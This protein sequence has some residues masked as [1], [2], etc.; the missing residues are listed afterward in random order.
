MDDAKLSYELLRQMKHGKD[1]LG[2]LDQWTNPPVPFSQMMS[3]KLERV[4]TLPQIHYHCFQIPKKAG[5]F[6]Q[7][8]APLQPLKGLQHSIAVLLGMVFT[9][10][11]HATGFVSGRSIVDNARRHVGKR[12][13][14][15]LDLKDFF[16]SIRQDR[17]LHS[18]MAEPFGLQEE[19][20]RFIASACCYTFRH[21]R[22]VLAQG[23]PTSPILS[24]IV[25]QEMDRRLQSLA[26]QFDLE[27][28][29]YADDI[30]F[31]GNRYVF[32]EKGTFWNRLRGIIQFQ[33]FQINKKKTRLQKKGERQEV[34]GLTVGE[35]VNVDK[36]Y[37]RQ[38]RTILHLWETHGTAYMKWRF[39]RDVHTDKH[40]SADPVLVIGG[41]LN[42]LKMVR[43][44]A[45]PCYLKLQ[46]RFDRLRK[47]PSDWI[48]DSYKPCN[49]N[50][51]YPIKPKYQYFFK[52]MKTQKI[53]SLDTSL[54]FGKYRGCTI[55]ELVVGKAEQNP[56]Q[57]TSKS[58]MRNPGYLCWLM[59]DADWFV[60]DENA[61]AFC[62][63]HGAIGDTE[64][65]LNKWKLKHSDS[66]TLS[67]NDILL[68]G[69]ERMQKMRSTKKHGMAG[70]PTGFKAL[71][72]M[73]GGLHKGLV[74]VV[75]GR[76]GMGKTS[77]VLSIALNQA[78]GQK[79]PVAFFSLESDASYIGTWLFSLLGQVSIHD[80]ARGILDPN[81]HD[82][83]MKKVAKLKDAPLFIDTAKQ[84]AL[85]QLEMKIVNMVESHFVK[86][87]IIDNIQ[88]LGAGIEPDN[89]SL[90][91]SKAMRML[92]RVAQMADVAIVLTSALNR[93]VEARG[94]D[95]KPILSDL[96]DS[97][98]IEQYSDVVLMLYRPEYYGI[99]YDDRG[100]DTR[101]VLEVI[102]SKNRL[103][104]IG[105]ARLLM[106]LKE[107]IVYDRNEELTE[108]HNEWEM[109]SSG[110]SKL[111]GLGF[112]P[113]G[114]RPF[115]EDFPF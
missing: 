73:I 29:R 54:D 58:D 30:T 20:A 14:L 104:A 67:A 15:N 36:Q 91:I 25:C 10:D 60:M 43:G 31:S 107:G 77:F 109:D 39:R 2:Y 95:K 65:Q 7:I 6:R 113:I 24:N 3:K 21:G 41:K 40:S 52:T 37:I 85:S 83:L 16:P 61:M 51:T 63:A 22:C 74:Y 94:G 32:S 111:K 106:D 72:Q 69:M 84:W 68:S 70:V 100:A 110:L 114:P 96:R 12:F 86:V 81:D 89:I 102:T 90:G 8:I 76:P 49:G 92:R 99:D 45:D 75:A 5:G 9:P 101:D 66:H 18:L 78:I 35:R 80:I 88:L 44:E 23:A 59:G 62:L 115:E 53:Y 105:E 46:S 11:E 79:S 38:L 28:S 97:G 42:Y 71:D 98:D 87:L 56:V 112:S 19:A 13:V 1:V 57:D 82:Q 27:Y 64:V 34:T 93:S 108:S 103:G 4:I 47:L 26:D 33:G 17:V 50:K 48:P 55:R